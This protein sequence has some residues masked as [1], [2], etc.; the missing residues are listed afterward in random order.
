M[1]PNYRESDIR[2]LFDNCEEQFEI[3]KICRGVNNGDE[4]VNVDFLVS[5]FD[6]NP[7]LSERELD[8]FFDQMVCVVKG[9]VKEE[10]E[11]E[12]GYNGSAWRC[13]DGC[14]SESDY[15]FVSVEII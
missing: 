8:N 1:K 2:E 10:C 11:L 4:V 5:V 12:Y 6:S 14:C 7:D 13:A 3:L 9:Y 15:Y